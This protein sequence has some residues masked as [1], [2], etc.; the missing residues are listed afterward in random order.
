MLNQVVVAFGDAD[1]TNRVIKAFQADGTFWAGATVW[2]NRDAMRISV[3]GWATTDADIEKSL[4][5]ILKA[6]REA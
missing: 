6:H 1:R 2:K 3:S 5:A 4:D